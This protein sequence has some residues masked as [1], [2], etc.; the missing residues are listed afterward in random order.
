MMM[1]DQ[2]VRCILELCLIKA[3]FFQ[4]M[5][6]LESELQFAVRF[7]NQTLDFWNINDWKLKTFLSLIQNLYIET[8]L[9][10]VKNKKDPFAK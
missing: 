4:N 9:T 2:F 6:V 5:R 1:I 10:F 7:A 8:I 3:C